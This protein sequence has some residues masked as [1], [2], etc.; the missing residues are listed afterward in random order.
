MSAEYPI[1]RSLADALE[2][3]ALRYAA[4]DWTPA[5]PDL[6]VSIDLKPHSFGGA[7]N[8]IEI[9]DDPLPEDLLNLLMANI[10]LGDEDLE[11]DL[12]TRRPYSSGARTLRLLMQRKREAYRNF[13]E[14]RR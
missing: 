12:A 6:L 7:C 4:R 13:E 3:I 14:L 9:F 2:D 11:D 1:S 10:H 5:G 8:L